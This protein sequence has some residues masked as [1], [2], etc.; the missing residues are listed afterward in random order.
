MGSLAAT[1]LYVYLERRLKETNR[2]HEVFYWKGLPNFVSLIYFWLKIEYYKKPDMH[3]CLTFI[4]DNFFHQ[5]CAEISTN[6]TLNTIF[7]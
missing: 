4:N 2:F 5:N 1:C 7:P 3:F 6:P